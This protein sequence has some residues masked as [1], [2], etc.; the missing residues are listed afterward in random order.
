M[1]GLLLA[2][3]SITLMKLQFYLWFNKKYCISNRFTFLFPGIHFIRS[4]TNSL[5]QMLCLKNHGGKIV[6]KIN[7]P[8]ISPCRTQSNSSS[9]LKR[10]P[11]EALFSES[12]WREVRGIRCR[13]LWDRECSHDV[14]PPNYPSCTHGESRNSGHLQQPVM[15]MQAS[16]SLW[17]KHSKL[18]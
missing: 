15:I 17:S 16:P 1:P 13:T 2:L 12:Q 6:G 4:L 9:T 5:F 14:C 10:F 11:R 18:I 7:Y 3:N 8:L